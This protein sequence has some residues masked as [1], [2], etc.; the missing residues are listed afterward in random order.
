M[1]IIFTEHLNTGVFKDREHMMK[2]NVHETYY[3]EINLPISLIERND[4][5]SKNIV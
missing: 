1:F 3:G 5:V 2:H 4:D